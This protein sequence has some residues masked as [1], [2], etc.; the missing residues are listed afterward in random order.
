MVPIN[1][2][3]LDDSFELLPRDRSIF[4]DVKIVKNMFQEFLIVKVRSLQA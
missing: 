3:L 2:T 1:S 4:I